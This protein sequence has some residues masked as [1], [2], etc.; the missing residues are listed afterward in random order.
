MNDLKVWYELSYFEKEWTV[1]KFKEVNYEEHGGYGSLGVFSSPNKQACLDY[2]EK[3]N[4]KLKNRR[5]KH[6]RIR[7]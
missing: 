2:C 5:V 4:I 6:D 3:N 1:W 7:L